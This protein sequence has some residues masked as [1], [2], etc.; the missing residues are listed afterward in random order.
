MCSNYHVVY[1]TKRFC[2]NFGLFIHLWRC[3]MTKLL[4]LL[5]STALVLIICMFSPCDAAIWG[6]KNDAKK[7]TDASNNMASK[8]W[9]W[10]T[11]VPTRTAPPVLKVCRPPDVCVLRLSFGVYQL[12]AVNEKCI[13]VKYAFFLFLSMH[14]ESQVCHLWSCSRPR[15]CS[16]YA[17]IVTSFG[18]ISCSATCVDCALCTHH[19]ISV[20]FSFWRVLTWLIIVSSFGVIS[21]SA[22]CIDCALCTHRTHD[23]LWHVVRVKQGF[24]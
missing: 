6:K 11:R 16:I 9:S 15:L 4:I 8:V 23:S 24:L 17:I 12:G 2:Y 3:R 10:S 20:E 19:H 22:T 14:F 7:T 5:S 1:H 18:V 21:C 13:T